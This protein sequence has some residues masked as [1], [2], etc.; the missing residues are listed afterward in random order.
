MLQAVYLISLHDNKSCSLS[1]LLGNLLGFH[2]LGELQV[3]RW[4]CMNFL[5][6]RITVSALGL[7][8]LCETVMFTDDI[9]CHSLERYK[10]Q[11]S[12]HQHACLRFAA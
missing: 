2:S 9:A 7:S 3:N 5:L 10:W 6:Q 8:H 12:L 1:I 11:Q 4:A